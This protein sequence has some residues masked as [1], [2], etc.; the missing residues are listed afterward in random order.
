MLKHKRLQKL[1]DEKAKEFNNVAFIEHDPVKIPHQFSRKQDI[2]IA[3][4]FS[5]ILAWGNRTTII[6][7]AQ[8]LMSM[9]DNA[10]F[11]FVLHH[12][13][14]DLKKLLSFKH[15]TFNATDLLYFIAFLRYHYKHHISLEEAFFIKEFSGFK[16]PHR[17]EKCLNTFHKYFFSLPDA[18]LRTQKHIAAPM[19]KST[20]KR[21][22]MF[23]RWMVRKDPNGV[24]F[25]IWKRIK[26]AELMCPLD[27]HVEK[28][29]RQLGL[30]TRPQRDWQT[31]VE[32]TNALKMFDA[33][34]PVKYDYAL[35]GLSIQHR[36]TGLNFYE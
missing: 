6:Q 22:N 34:D 31:V 15:R 7:S 10:P 17:V 27:V 4:F 36:K 8:K 20:C 33:Q 29:A 35:F 25:G 21:L 24:D 19:R 11:E 28:T 30:I 26:P 14:N 1:L 9:M 23:L 5:A 18:P 13:E 12:K 2:E 32:L 3:G 16:T